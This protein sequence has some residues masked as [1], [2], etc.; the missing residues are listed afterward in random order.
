MN[1]FLL[2]TAL[3]LVR[4]QRVVRRAD[5]GPERT[6][7]PTKGGRLRFG[8]SRSPRSADLLGRLYECFLTRF[9]SAEG[10]NGGQFYTPYCVVRCLLEPVPVRKDLAPYNARIDDSACGTGG[11]FAR[12]EKLVEG[13]GGTGSQR[14]IRRALIEA[15][16]VDCM[17]AL[18]GQLFDNTE[19]P[20]I[21]Q[22]AA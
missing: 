7:C 5:P 21:V 11:M 16:L 17:V 2:R 13:H 6:R 3:Q 10:K 4:F 12:S 14:D 18:P 19:I 8:L 20:G 22:K 15:D 1:V 9:A